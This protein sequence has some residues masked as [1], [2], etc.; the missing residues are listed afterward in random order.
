M[1]SGGSRPGAGRPSKSEADKRVSLVLSV[2]PE[3]KEWLKQAAWEQGCRMGNIVEQ[4]IDMVR[5]M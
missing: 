2:A 1:A 5:T 3:T 4:L